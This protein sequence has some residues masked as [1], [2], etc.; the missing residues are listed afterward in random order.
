MET[1]NAAREEGAAV[2]RRTRIIYCYYT[3]PAAA[4]EAAAG[5]SLR[6]EAAS[7]HR[8]SKSVGVQVRWVCGMVVGW[9]CMV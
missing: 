7:F 4:A 1:G 9:Q 3:P 2:C 5:E 8:P 6:R